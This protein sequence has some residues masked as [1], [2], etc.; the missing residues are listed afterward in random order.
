MRLCVAIY[1]SIKD[2][3][4]ANVEHVVYIIFSLVSS[5]P[6]LN[7]LFNPFIY[8]VRMRYFRVA[9]I[10][11]LSRKTIQQAEDLER[12]IFRPRQIGVVA[13]VEQGQNGA[14]QEE[15]EQQG[16]ETLNIPHETAARAQPQ[17]P[18]E[19]APL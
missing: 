17:E 7:S 10:Q 3:I 16:N 6:I 8:A 11:L 5:L 4:A 12:K 19:E 1:V 2:R 15:D 9:F 14:G 13:N 18:F